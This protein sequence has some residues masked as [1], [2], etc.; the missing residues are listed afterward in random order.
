MMVETYLKIYTHT[1]LTVYFTARLIDPI[2]VHRM[3]WLKNCHEDAASR[4][5]GKLLNF[6][7]QNDRKVL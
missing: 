6:F 3:L 1:S 4:K 5:A 2:D 7:Y